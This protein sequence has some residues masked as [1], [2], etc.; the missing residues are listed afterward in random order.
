VSSLL[1]A[2]SED[3]PV[4]VKYGKEKIEVTQEQI[5]NMMF[6]YDVYPVL[7]N[8]IDAQEKRITVIE[9]SWTSAEASAS[10]WKGIAIGT[11]TVAI[12]NIMVNILI[13][14]LRN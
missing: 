10:M 2:V 9:E 7:N 4:D 13:G 6:Y 5:A 3:P 1:V 12:L 14:I 11:G 8:R